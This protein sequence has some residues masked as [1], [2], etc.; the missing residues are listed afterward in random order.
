VLEVG[1]TRAQ[2]SSKKKKKLAHTAADDEALAMPAEEALSK[3]RSKARD[4]SRRAQ[5]AKRKKL[6]VF[7]VH[8]TLLDCSLLIDKNPNAAIKPTIRSVELYFAL[9]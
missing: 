5:S 9:A 3:V 1:G 6:Q 4:I 8:G 7:N 2:Q